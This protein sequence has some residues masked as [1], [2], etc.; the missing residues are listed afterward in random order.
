MSLGIIVF[1][2]L[3]VWWLVLFVVLPV[4]VKRAENPAP[5]HS[6]GA[7]ENARLKEKF[8]ATTLVAAVI[9]AI[10]YF[11][12]GN[13]SAQDMPAAAEAPKAVKADALTTGIAPGGCV[14]K[15]SHEPAEDVEYTPGVDTNGNVLTPADTSPP[16]LSSENIRT[17][18]ISLDIPLSSR[19]DVA[20]YDSNLDLSRTDMH[21]GTLE[22]EKNDV[23]LNGTSLK[24][25]DNYQHED[26]SP[27]Q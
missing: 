19:V 22:V 10:I 8:I 18:K 5:G 12:V 15:P 9:T 14:R 4:G 6:H 2:Y 16:P 25:E 21:I 27:A 13:A 1:T 20:P 3:N 24:S 26:C 7:P 23:K 17:P 11:F